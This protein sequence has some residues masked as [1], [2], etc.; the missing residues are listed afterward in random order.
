MSKERRVAT[1]SAHALA[2]ESIALLREYPGALLPFYI[3]AAPFWLGFLYFFSDMSQ[4]AYATEHLLGG[5]LV[6]SLLYL[7]MKCWQTVFATKLRAALLLEPDEDW[8]AARIFRLIATQAAWQPWGLI[9]RPIALIITLPFVW[10]SSFF[11]NISVLG[12]GRVP[13]NGQTVGARAW[14]QAQLW[15]GQAHLLVAML[16][17]FGLV[18]WLNIASAMTAVPALLKMFFDIET[19]ASRNLLALALNSTFFSA[20]FALTML[21]LDPIWKTAYVL[22]CFHGESLRTGEDLLV[23]LKKLQRPA[24]GV[25]AALLVGGFLFLPAPSA[26]AQ[27]PVGPQPALAT[28]GDA[29]RATQLERSID[30]VLQEREYAWRMPREKGPKKEESLIGK[31]LKRWGESLKKIGER[32]MEWLESFFKKKQLDQGESGG[33]LPVQE[34]TYLLVA[35]G[36]LLLAWTVWTVLRKHTTPIVT[37]EAV[38]AV[39]D[40]NAEDVVADQLPVDGWLR[41]MQ[42]LL[43]AGELRLALRAAYL[44]TLAHLG[45]RELLAI[46]R[47]KSNRDYHRELQRRA[48]SREALLAAF[49]ENL[50]AFE[51]SWYG[52]HEVT[53][54]LLTRFSQNL[55]TIRAC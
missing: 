50:Q 38:Q 33:G 48:R 44:A 12:D 35:A 40:L 47:Y 2:G 20:S 3:G 9:V 17:L 49:E 53:R 11:Q 14:A 29:A 1:K 16:S 32:F 5:A 55:E 8:T 34:I 54:D 26:S 45:Q 41:I 42:D 4:S 39:P 18:I 37:A 6:L 25:L 27:A 31:T 30:R 22:R 21:C 46:A 52:Q 24:R 7:W 10:V 19:A 51:R 28:P 13:A 23:E 36:V 43:N 15:P